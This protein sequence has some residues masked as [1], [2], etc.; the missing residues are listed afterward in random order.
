MNGGERWLT[1]GV[2][3]GL[4]QG[5][6]NFRKAWPSHH[7]GRRGSVYMVYVVKGWEWVSRRGVGMGWLGAGIAGSNLG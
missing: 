3:R 1:I 4:G 2:L 7:K 5:S 6:R